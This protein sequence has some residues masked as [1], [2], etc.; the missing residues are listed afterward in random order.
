MAMTQAS[1]RRH[2][3]DAGRDCGENEGLW[4]S[5]SSSRPRARGGW[6][7]PWRRRP[8]EREP[9]GMSMWLL[10]SWGVYWR[11]EGAR[12]QRSWPGDVVPVRVWT[13]AVRALAWHGVSGRARARQV[14]ALVVVLLAQ[15][16]VQHDQ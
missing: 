13:L 8:V 1:R 6:R 2:G 4:R 10:R 16:C 14:L 3:C 12:G 11:E 9:M 7:W 5:S 15:G